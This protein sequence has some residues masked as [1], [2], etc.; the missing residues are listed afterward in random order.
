MA[1]PAL[2][3]IFS[4]FQKFFIA[5]GI[6]W[7]YNVFVRGDMA[8]LVER[9]VRNAKARGS[10]P[11]ISTQNKETLCVSMVFFC[12][13]LKQRIRTGS[14][15]R[16]W[17]MQRANEGIFFSSAYPFFMDISDFILAKQ[18]FHESLQTTFVTIHDKF[19]TKN[20]ITFF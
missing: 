4:P 19:V 5:F 12:F 9:R 17:R 1:S 10:N 6:F 3:K 11:L 14:E 18:G 16:Q 7:D 13:D 20:K 8:Q 15:R 2:Q